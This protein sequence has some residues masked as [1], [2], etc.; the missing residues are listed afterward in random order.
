MRIRSDHCHVC[1]IAPPL[2]WSDR[3][4]NNQENSNIGLNL[5]FVLERS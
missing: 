5:Y 3:D 1:A 2:S 4:V